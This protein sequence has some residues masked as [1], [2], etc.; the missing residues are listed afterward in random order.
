MLRATSSYVRQVLLAVAL[1]MAC[2][3]VIASPA[4]AAT[5]AL[6][7]TSEGK[8]RKVAVG[9]YAMTI[10]GL[11]QQDNSY[12][13]DFYFWLRW[14]GAGDPSATVEFMNNVERWGLTQTPVYEEPKK[15]ASGEFTQ[16]FHVQGKFFA[17]LDLSDYPLDDHE[18]P[19]E[20][21]DASADDKQQVYVLD[22]VQSG[23]D[24]GVRIPGWKIDGI[25]LT[26]G[27][28]RYK[29]T[30]G[31]SVN[32]DKSNFAR[33]TFA[34][35]I[36]RPTNFFLL[37]LFLPLVIVML[38]AIST[39]LV[40]P[41][42]ADIRLAAPVT[43]LLALVFLQQSYSSTLPENGNLVLL[44]RIYVLSYALIVAL[45]VVTILTSHW[46]RADDDEG[47]IAHL[48]KLD[49]W[50]AGGLTA[51]FAVGSGILIAAS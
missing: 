27:D 12:Y 28:H 16:Q 26:S 46:A 51:V 38:V 42:Q 35:K 43:A 32:H 15:L 2:G 29:T 19:I 20:I 37:K 33:A 44:D 21:E 34:I 48:K 8:P 24:P 3:G 41:T 23:L 4:S 50:V 9:F 40:N 47:K 11:D 13:A 36:D 6:A 45:I 22:Q 49:R 30:F 1:V 10:Q 5:P 31:E 7:E 17:P 25:R 18:L 14:R 39:L